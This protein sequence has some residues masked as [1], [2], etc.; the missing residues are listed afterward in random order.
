M[1]LKRGKHV[2]KLPDYV[3]SISSVEIRLKKNWWV[4]YQ[5]IS[6][7]PS[8]PNRI[9]G[10]P[11]FYH[12]RKNQKECLLILNCAPKKCWNLRVNY[13]QKHSL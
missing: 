8:I 13:W 4:L 10:L 1:R 7:N 6:L 11:E 12:F 5:T 3:S 9:D 2:Y